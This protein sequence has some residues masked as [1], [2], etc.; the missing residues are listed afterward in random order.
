MFEHGSYKITLIDTP[1]FNDTNRSETE[2]LRAIADYLDFT[3]RNPP[4]LKL[5]GIIY[6]QS[7]MDPRMYGSSLRNLKMFKDLCGEDPL[8]NVILATTKWGTATRAGETDLA[9][10][11][12]EQ[13]CKSEDFWAPMIQRGSRMERFEDT[14]ESALNMLLSLVKKEPVVL[15]IQTELAKGMPLID[16]T[17]GTTVNEETKRLE[18]KYQKE[19]ADIQE[20]MKTLQAKDLDVQEALKKAESDFQRK[21]DRVHEE[22]NLLRYESRN[23]DRRM[24]QKMDEL[25]LAYEKE[26]TKKLGS[27]QLDFDETVAKLRA[28]EAKLRKEQR[29]LMDA[30]IEKMQKANKGDRTVIKLLASLI[31]T[32]GTVVLGILGVTT[33]GT[34]S[35]M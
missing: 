19:I 31:P 17:A 35:V 12:E 9:I 5:T 30:E 24:Q 15:Q 28:N 27:Q 32:V 7:I 10:E 6:L 26:L 21:L 18:V 4:H 34:C 20:E 1:G 16:T 25:R 8:K 23:K 33:G 14:R 13:L 2:V 3:F 22:Q 11:R 29:E